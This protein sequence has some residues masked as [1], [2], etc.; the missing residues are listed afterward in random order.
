M[1]HHMEERSVSVELPVRNEYGEVVSSE[2]IDLLPHGQGLFKVAHS[3]GFSEGFAKGDTLLLGAKGQFEV[4]DRSGWVVVWLF[5]QRMSSEDIKIIRSQV[6]KISG[7]VD[8]GYQDSLLIL[9]LPIS[10]GFPMIENTANELASRLKDGEW[11]YGN[12]Y[13]PVDGITPL[14]WWRESQQD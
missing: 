7:H 4:V 8:G 10:A 6:A 12:V 9:N 14:N 11:Q 13:D 2:K 1:A 3:P 5:S